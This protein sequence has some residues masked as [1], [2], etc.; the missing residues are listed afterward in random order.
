LV[1]S[2]GSTSQAVRDLFGVG[3]LEFEDIVASPRKG[4]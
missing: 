2:S 1:L 4:S 3:H